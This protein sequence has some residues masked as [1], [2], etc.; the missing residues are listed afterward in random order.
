MT[1]KDSLNSGAGR[2]PAEQGVR[3]SPN[4]LRLLLS[5]LVGCLVV[6]CTTPTH[7]L[8]E[9][10]PP[11]T[12]IVARTGDQSVLSWQSR[13]GEIYTVL[14]ADGS[15]VGVDWKPLQGAHRIHGTGQEVR[16]T[17]RMPSGTI[18]YYRLMVVPADSRPAR[19]GR[20]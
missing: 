12:L 6:S 9:E 7:E 3:V 11:A 1:K 18:R 2:I 14:Y 15:R 16:L 5:L 20:R 4:P 8:I 17:D 19:S 13:V 10:P